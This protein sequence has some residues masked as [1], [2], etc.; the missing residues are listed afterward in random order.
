MTR[1]SVIGLGAMGRPIA[2]NLLKAGHDVTVWNRSLESSLM[3]VD[4]GASAAATPAE[5]FQT[6]IVFSMLSNDEAVAEVLLDPDL[7]RGV[8]AGTVHVNL[9]TVSA[10]LAE[11]AAK[12]H[13]DFEVG[14][15]SAPVFGRV[16]VAEAGNLNILAAGDEALIHRVQPLFDVIGAKTWHMGT[17]PGRAN[18]VK[19]I[20]NYLIAC[21]IQ[22]MGEAVSL[23][24]GAGVD[25]AQVIELLTSTLF[26]GVV[27]SSYG[28][29]IA[30]REYQPA[31]LSTALGRKDLHLALAEAANQGT[32]LPFGEVLRDTFERAISEGRGHDD[33]A[34]IT[35]LLPRTNP[36]TPRPV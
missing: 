4:A 21:A 7:L 10:E 27:Y 23:A 34:S 29:L 5:A 24:E 36:G 2:Q 1:V 12:L 16:P 22:S 19:I 9:S 3:L 18:V 17:S 20:G 31:G 28:N 8:P 6:G 26:P 15:V 33:W 25:A 30:T 35:E 11:R 32:V 13:A 14:Y